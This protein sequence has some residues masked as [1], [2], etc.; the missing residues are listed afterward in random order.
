MTPPGRHGPVP[1]HPFRRFTYYVASFRFVIVELGYTKQ[2][3][4]YQDE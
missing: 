4:R 3:G 2:T 1:N